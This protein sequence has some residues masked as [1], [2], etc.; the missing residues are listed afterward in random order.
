MRKLIRLACDWLAK[1]DGASIV[2]YAAL[3]GL[4]AIICVAAISLLGTS[5]SSIFAS[6]AGSM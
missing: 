3:L 2:E 6:L 5:I 1:E 4:V